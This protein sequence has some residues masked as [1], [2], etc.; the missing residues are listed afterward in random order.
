MTPFP[1]TPLFEEMDR[2]GRVRLADKQRQ[3]TG[4]TAEVVLLGVNDH[5]EVRDRAEWQAQEQQMLADQHEIFTY[6]FESAD[7]LDSEPDL[8]QGDT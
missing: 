5:L 7:A 1:G 6:I 4:L 3:L 2:Q 8:D